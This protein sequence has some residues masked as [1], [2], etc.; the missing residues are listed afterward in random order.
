[1][2]TLRE[3]V[4]L[5]ATVGIIVGCAAGPQTRLS[6]DI[7]DYP[8]L[9]LETL[10]A[11]P[12]F[13]APQISPDGTLIS[14]IAPNDGA[15]NFFVAPVNDISAARP[16]TTYTGRGVRATDV[17][18][19]VMYRWH[20]DSR[21][22]IYPMDYDGDENW[23]MHVVDVQTG[24]DRNLTPTPDLSVEIIAY[25]RSHP[26][27]ALV[28]VDTFGRR[29][30][31][32][33]RLNLATGERALVQKNDGAIGYL[34]DN[35]LAV[36][37]ALRFTP[38]GGL[39]FQRREEDGSWTSI[40]V[41]GSDDLPAVSASVFQKIIR[42]D[43]TNRFLYLY[44]SIGRNAAAL[45]TLDLET[46]ETRLIAE[47]PRSDIAGVLYHPVTTAVQ[48]Y[49]T[50]WT[51]VE[52]HILD[53]SVAADA[54]RLGEV[55]DGDWTVVSASDDDRRWIVRYMLSHEP[56]TFYLFDR[57]SGSA[58]RLFSST[59]QL[60]GLKLSRMFPYE[61]ETP[62]GLPLVGY[63]T[64]PPWTDPDEDGRPDHPVPM[65]TYVHGGPS[66]ERPMFA[67]GPIVHWLANRGYGFLYVNFR[68][69]AGFGKAFM[70]A[71]KMEWGGKMHTDVLQQVQWAID[72]GIADPDRVA[73]L[74]G[75]Y[76]GYETLVG[77]TMTPDVFACGVDIVGPSNL[78]IF[79]PHWDVDRMSKVIGDPRTE[80]GRAFLRSRSPINF[81]QDTKHPVLIGQGARDSRVPQD[82]SDT[83]VK[84]MVEA[85]AQVTYAVFPDEGHGFLRPANS[86]AFNAVME[87]FLG[88]CLGGRYEPI[89]DQIEGSSL[90]VPVGVEHIPGLAEALAARTETGL[91][92]TEVVEVD[93]AVLE[94]YA[95]SYTLAGYGVPVIVEVKD[96]RIFLQ[97]TGQPQAEMFPTSAT[98]FFF[99]V[100]PST[101]TF[102]RGADGAVSHL[103]LYSGGSETRADRVN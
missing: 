65:I 6:G 49:A 87:V 35:D 33:Y 26:D 79:M 43:P 81:A 74:G 16:V 97:V 9:P 86:R 76:G 100:A 7:N 39:D 11:E 56:I 82:Q 62:D 28:S 92:S 4:F 73:I 53:D 70:N 89:T 91:P 31:D 69:S 46:G 24:E 45:V 29:Q 94:A 5:T 44:D 64:L 1:M 75:S 99:K 10:L 20:L 61:L 78:E 22:L 19:V 27:E 21:H 40:Y 18:G 14:Y 50:N 41:V 54:Q 67:F 17:S 96:G 48:A 72:Q 95:G 101:V 84:K 2:K 83:V 42:V 102:F 90:E 85:G 47:D 8:L 34:G 37:A 98:D 12:S 52:W 57:G 71:Y 3:I 93:P 77:M 60:E 66:D 59:P 25:G 58:T 80:E 88:Q 15:P 51:R 68:G 55:A 38:E 13:V 63:V 36:R 32:V 30:P 103:I 23:D